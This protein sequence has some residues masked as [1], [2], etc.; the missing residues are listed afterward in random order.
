M[1]DTQCASNE[2]V[3][4]EILYLAN[5][6]AE[7]DPTHRASRSKLVSDVEQRISMFDSSVE[8]KISLSLLAAPHLVSTA[9]HMIVVVVLVY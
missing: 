5:S 4:S 7:P 6:L 3:P 2:Q 1:T 9:G 8:P